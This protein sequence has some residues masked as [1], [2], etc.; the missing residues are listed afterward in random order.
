[1]QKPIIT[2]VSHAD[3]GDTISLQLLVDQVHFK[4]TKDQK[5]FLL[6]VLRDRSGKINA[7]KWQV[8]KELYHSLQVGTVVHAQGRV[9]EHQGKLQIVLDTITPVEDN[10]IDWR[11][12]LPGSTIDQAALWKELQQAVAA[13]ES[14]HLQKLMNAVFDDPDL[15]ERLKIWPAGKS[16]HHACVGGLL[17]HIVS[18]LKY[19]QSLVRQWPGLSLDLLTAGA[20]LHDLGKLRE[21]TCRQGIQYSNRGQLIGHTQIGLLMLHELVEKIPD[22]PDELLLEL[23]H[24]II[25][26]HGKLEFGASKEPATAEA[27]ALHFLD[28][29]DARLSAYFTS[30]EN[31]EHSPYGKD[32]TDFNRL[33]NN[34]LY[35]PE[36]LQK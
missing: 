35:I 36:R 7:V 9:Q 23:E 22:F 5:P 14:P 6:L 33:F 11:S 32:W 1:M 18:I 25:S 3:R 27:I 10:R 24:M 17:E 13:I 4:Q 8:N 31:K 26:H 16:L 2:D 28:N 12:F 21:I 15:S 29:L 30:L 19:A 34:R 20:V